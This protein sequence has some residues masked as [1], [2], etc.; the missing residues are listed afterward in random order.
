MNDI[1]RH[2]WAINKSSAEILDLSTNICFDR[3]L[4]SNTNVNIYQYPTEYNNYNHLSKHYDVSINNIAIGLGLGELIPRIFSCFRDKSFTITLPNWQLL[5]ILCKVN[6]VNYHIINYKNFNQIDVS[7]LFDK[8][9]DILYITNPNGVNGS[10][11]NRDTILQLSDLYEIVIV[12]EAYMDFSNQ[13]VI[14][15]LKDNII[16]CKSFSKTIASPGLRFGYCFSGSSIIKKLQDNR[17]GYV[18]CNYDIENILKEI[19]NHLDRMIETRTYIN[20]NFDTIPSYG[21]FILFNGKPKINCMMKEVY[22]GI[23]RMSLTDLETF[24]K[25]CDNIHTQR[26]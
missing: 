26:I 12:D 6:Q 23:Y 16:V 25:L 10:I 8:K 17:P 1:L 13:S 19:P 4:S 5:E 14:N 22:Q 21:N 20:N 24:K 15:C 7:E 11:V 9:S 2:Y 18:M 3:Y